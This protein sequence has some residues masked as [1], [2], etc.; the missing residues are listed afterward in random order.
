MATLLEQESRSADGL[1]EDAQRKLK[2]TNPVEA[3]RILMQLKAT[4]DVQNQSAYVCWAVSNHMNSA[5]TATRSVAEGLRD[6][7]IL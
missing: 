5:R 1:D 3:M 7:A 4:P 6:R 2:E